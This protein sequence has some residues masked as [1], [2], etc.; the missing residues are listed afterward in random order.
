MLLRAAGAGQQALELW[1]VVLIGG[2]GMLVA[3]SRAGS[4]LFWRT[5]DDAAPRAELDRV[6]A[7]ATIGLLACSP[8]L[9]VAAQPVYAYTQATAQQLLDVGAYL[10]LV[11]GGG[12]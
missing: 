3:L 4:V 5:M 6:R 8:L 2:L 10:Q 7:L 11:R 12:A 1:P 9:V